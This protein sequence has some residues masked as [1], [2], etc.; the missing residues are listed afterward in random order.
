MN[1]AHEML[2][3]VVEYLLKHC[4]DEVEFFNNHYDDKLRD[5]LEALVNS[6]FAQVSYTDA[7]KILQETAA[8]TGEKF[9]YP[10]SWGCDLQTD[11]ERYLTDKVFKKPVFV[12][13]YPR[14]IK[15]FYMR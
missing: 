1:L 5:R 10:V 4:P 9:D 13:D 8:A 11:H 7:I 14:E 6:D 3:F 2:R 12:T 15:A